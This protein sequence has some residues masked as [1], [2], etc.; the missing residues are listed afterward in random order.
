MRESVKEMER[1]MLNEIDLIAR[2]NDSN[3]DINV[4]LLKE[5]V[6]LLCELV[7]IGFD[8]QE[9]ADQLEQKLKDLVQK[10]L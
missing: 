9:E 1:M 10:S 5:K 7:D 8:K 4:T 2:G 6:K 3:H